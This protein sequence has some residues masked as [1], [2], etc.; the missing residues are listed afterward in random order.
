MEVIDFLFSQYS[1]YSSTHIVLE[2]TAVVA[3]VVSVLYSYRNSFLVFPFGIVST[4]IFTYLLVNWNLLGDAV[5]NLYYLIMSIYGWYLWIKG[6]KNNK[7]LQ[8]SL[9][10]KQQWIRAI[11][12]S[13]FAALCIYI[14]YVSTN[15]MENVVS[16]IDM[17]TTGLFFAGM[18][19]MA[20]R[21]LEHW[22]VL[23]IGNFISIPLYFYKGYTFSAFLYLFLLIMAVAGFYAWKKYLNNLIIKASV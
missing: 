1:E 11:T 10:S 22:L 7:E 3:S 4:A 2:L 9:T 20:K 6:G 21:K 23:G 5:I 14:L 18:W 19:L 15:R 8:I 16:Y 12:I 13:I 17:V